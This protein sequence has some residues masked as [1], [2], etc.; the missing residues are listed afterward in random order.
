MDSY[1]FAAALGGAG[2]AAM[3]ALGVSHLGGGQHQTHGGHDASGHVGTAHG[4]AASLHGAH[5]PVHAHGAQAHL[6]ALRAGARGGARGGI[7][8]ALLSLMSPRVLFS[9]ALGFGITGL[10][11]RPLIGGVALAAAA[12]AGGVL[13]EAAVVRPIWNLLFRFASTPAASLEGTLLSEATATSGFDA[14]G[15]GIVALEVDGQMVQ[16]LGTL[17]S[18]DRELGVRVRSGDVLRV[19]DVD[20]A[21]NRCTVSYVRRGVDAR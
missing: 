21:R 3:A 20:P 5:M 15:Q 18:T 9:V 14:N 10:L 12:V 19:E 16:C 4:D 11:L 1:T 7:R 6:P 8:P 2:L 13:L 17:R